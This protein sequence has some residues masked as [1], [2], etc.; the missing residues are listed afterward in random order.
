MFFKNF[1]SHPRNN[2]KNEIIE[3]EFQYLTL[4]TH[5]PLDGG[6]SE[7]VAMIL[8]ALVMSGVVLTL[9]HSESRLF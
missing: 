6:F 7:T 2:N 9:G 4:H 5:V 1:G 8:S 3:L